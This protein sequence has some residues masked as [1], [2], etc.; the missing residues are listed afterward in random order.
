MAD[1]SRQRDIFEQ[2]QSDLYGVALTQEQ[3][4][5]VYSDGTSDSLLLD[6]QVA[7]AERDND[8]SSENDVPNVSD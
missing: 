4:Q 8:A 2:I 7:E 6:G 5:N 3:L 1:Q